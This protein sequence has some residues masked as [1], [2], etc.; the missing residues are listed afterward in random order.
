VLDFID[1]DCLDE[2]ILL[3]HKGHEVSGRG[4]TKSDE[5]VFHVEK[6][7]IREEA[8]DGVPDESRFARLPWPYDK[9]SL[10]GIV[11]RDLGVSMDVSNREM[12]FEKNFPF[13]GLNK[14]GIELDNTLGQFCGKHNNKY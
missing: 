2:G 9:D 4:E 3:F 7:N 13:F 12:F 11:Q 14:P 10:S 1:E 6:E 5:R 8:F